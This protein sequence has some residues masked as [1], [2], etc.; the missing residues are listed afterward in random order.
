MIAR[1]YS[2]RT[3]SELTDS[4]INDILVDLDILLNEMIIKALTHGM[5]IRI[6]TKAQGFLVI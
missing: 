6:Y 3:I 5:V 2:T 1:T 4:Q